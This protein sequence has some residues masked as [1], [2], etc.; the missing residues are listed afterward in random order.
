MDALG[1]METKFIGNRCCTL[2]VIDE[3][4]DYAAIFILSKREQVYSAICKS[5]ARLKQQTGHKLQSIHLEGAG[6]HKREIAS[7]LKQV[8]GIILKSSPHYAPHSNGRAEGFMQ[9]ILVRAHVMLT[10]IG[11]PDTLWAEDINHAI[12]SAIYPTR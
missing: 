2:G 1:P 7:Q 4:S 11:L 6:E 9:E 10:N 3:D 12:R 8:E 5:M